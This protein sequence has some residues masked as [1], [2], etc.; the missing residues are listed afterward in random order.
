MTAR[1]SIA[2]SLSLL[3]SSCLDVTTITDTKT[4]P[5]LIFQTPGDG[6]SF[7][8]GESVSFLIKVDDD[9]PEEDVLISMFDTTARRWS[10]T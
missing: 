2:A 5:V 7:G 6:A 9:S 8:E 1:T 3:L 10:R 4:P